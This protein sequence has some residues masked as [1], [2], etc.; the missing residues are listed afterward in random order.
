MTQTTKR[1][2]P[3]TAGLKAQLEKERQ[4]RERVQERVR[5]IGKLPRVP[6]ARD[7]RGAVTA[8]MEALTED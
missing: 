4:W 8:L 5:A 3:S 1:G 7:L 6:T 2:R